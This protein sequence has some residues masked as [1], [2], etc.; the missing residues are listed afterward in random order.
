MHYNDNTISP[1]EEEQFAFKR[2]LSRLIEMTSQSY[3]R[4]EKWKPLSTGSRQWERHTSE[5]SSSPSWTRMPKQSPSIQLTND[6]FASE[7]SYNNIDPR[8]GR[9]DA[10][11]L[12][13]DHI[14]GVRDDWGKA[15]KAWGQGTKAN[16]D[17]SGGGLR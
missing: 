3:G 16:G 5:Q 2:A 6:D 11:R 8:K 4:D 14:W 13:N 9:P 10:P 12:K 15:A 17:S 1:G 7:A